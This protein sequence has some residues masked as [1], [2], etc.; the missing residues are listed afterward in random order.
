MGIAAASAGAQQAGGFRRY[1]VSFSVTN[2]DSTPVVCAPAA[3]GKTYTVTGTLTLPSSATPAAATLYVHGLGYD[4]DFW[5]FT[6]V[7]GYDY[8]AT[9]A[10]QGHASLAINRLGYPGSSIPNGN[11][12]CVGSQATMLHEIVADMRTGA[13][14][15]DDGSQAPAFSR[16]GL[17]GHSVGG[18]LAEIEAY[19]YK[20]VDAL[21]VVEWADQ[22]YSPGTYTAFGLAATQC[23]A[24]NV[25]QV[26]SNAGDYAA[27]GTTSASYNS[28]MFADIDPSVEA[29]AD[30]QR[31]RDPCGMIESI[32]TGTATD[33]LNVNKIKVPVAYVHAGKDGIFE[34]ALPW[35]KLQESLYTGTSKLTDISLPGEGHAVTL[36]RQAPTFAADMSAWLSANGL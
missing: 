27:F 7:P 1:S 13:Y 32:L 17:V 34:D 14:S 30:A 18:Q 21:G 9:E 25:D 19:T 16:V 26:G 20:D 15:V 31:T 36:E 28:L 6:S 4:S 23:V 29:A 33:L 3:D 22:F 10:Q 35:A 2:N 5:D 12:T 24:G 11:A 8:A